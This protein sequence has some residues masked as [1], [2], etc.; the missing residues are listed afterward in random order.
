VKV[1]VYGLWHLGTVTAACL[2]DAGFQTVGLD[3]NAAT[4]A[5]LQRGTPPIFEPGLAELAAANLQ[6]KRLSFST[7][8]GAVADADLVW[9]AFDT[10][11]DDQDRPDAAFVEERIRALFPHLK[12]GA[13]VLLSS[14]MPVGTTRRLS[15]Q[16]RA[17][18]E[19]RVGFAY[20][21]ENLRLGRA[22][23]VFK[24][25]ERIIVGTESAL[26]REVLQ[27]VL[28]RFSDQLLWMS[29]ESAEMVKHALNAFLATSITF[30]NEIATLC[31]RVGADAGE[32]ETGL[33][34]EPRIGP[35]AYIRPGPAFAGGTLARD[36]SVLNLLAERH[37]LAL[38]L[39]GSILSSNSQHR[40]WP[41]QRLTSYYPDLAGRKIAV[42][43]LTYKPGTDTL[44]R[45]TAIEL[46][47]KLAK[48]GCVLAAFDPAVKTVPPEIADIQLCASVEAALADADALVLATEWPAFRQLSP[49][50][51]IS[52]MRKPVILDQ[53]RFLTPDFAT[54]PRVVYM[55]IGKPT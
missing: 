32:V 51:C 14:Q 18:E 25:P 6:A 48:R 49:A 36:V 22:I 40:N 10:P 7:D 13:V 9:V 23:E 45:S 38:P 28:A 53:S 41:L 1:C 20:S 55:T 15:E 31:E 33:R 35:K 47:N 16:F 11:V 46:C 12:D 30:A 26:E 34:S 2:A 21:P 37:Q 3:D 24:H 29:L 8:L 43:G 5:A 54:D 52:H 19:R 39:L 50:V 42:L 44:R 27:P 17:Q 4:V